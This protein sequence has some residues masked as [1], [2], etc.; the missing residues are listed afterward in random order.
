MVKNEGE[1]EKFGNKAYKLNE[2]IEQTQS[3]FDEL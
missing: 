1:I 3:K 2:K